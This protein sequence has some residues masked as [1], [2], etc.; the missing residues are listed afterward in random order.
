M[1][2]RCQSLNGAGGWF[3]RMRQPQCRHGG[4]RD[5]AVRLRSLP[6]R[7]EP[8]PHWSIR[9]RRGTPQRAAGRAM[10]RAFSEGRNVMDDEDRVAMIKS[11]IRK[12]IESSV[13]GLCDSAVDLMVNEIYEA[14]ERSGWFRETVAPAPSC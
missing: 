11:E 14:L 7:S 3:A 2:Q 4:D 9:S 5:E 10:S 12:A 8:L 6:E 1:G 13:C